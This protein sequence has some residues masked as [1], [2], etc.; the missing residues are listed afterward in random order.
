M[1]FALEKHV[2]LALLLEFL[3]INQQEGAPMVTN[4]YSMATLKYKLIP[5][6]K[7][8]VFIS[9]GWGA[10]G[11][12]FS[13]LYMSPHSSKAPIQSES[14]YKPIPISSQ[15]PRMDKQTFIDMQQPRTYIKSR[16]QYSVIPQLFVSYGWGPMGRK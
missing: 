13:V 8:D 5:E 9:R 10:G 4:N 1:N 14:H 3:L 12:P 7:K 11:M 16:R 15:F 6:S 2:I